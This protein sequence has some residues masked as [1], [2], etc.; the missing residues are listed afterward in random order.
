VHVPAFVVRHPIGTAAIACAALF[1]ASAS[2]TAPAAAAAGTPMCATSG[3]VV[4]LNTQGNGAAGSVY[5]TLE[6]TNLSGHACTLFGYPGVSAVDLRG[7]QLGSAA[8]RNRTRKPRLVRLADA[9]SATVILQIVEVGN[10]PASACRPVTAA[11][12]RVYPP[13]QNAATIVPFPFRACSRAG[14]VYLT[15]QAV[16]KA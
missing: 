7:R 12:L 6:L 4:W 13:N 16:Q 1:A 9:A 11:G 8:S 15:V 2:P 10:L 14:P 5:Y 3:L